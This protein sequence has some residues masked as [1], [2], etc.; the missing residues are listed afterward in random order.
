LDSHLET[1]I[2]AEKYI[3]IAERLSRRIRAG[4][5]HLQPLPAERELAAEVG[6]SHATARKAVQ[7]LLDKGLLFRLENG[8]LSVNRGNRS[9]RKV[10][11]QIVLLAPAWESNE[12]TRWQIAATQLCSRFHC[13]LRVVHYAH[14]DDPLLLGS[15]ERFDG[16]LFMPIPEAMPDSFLPS[17]LQI[18]QPVVVLGRDWTEHGVPSMRLY[19]PALVQKLLDH[20]ASL[21]HQIIDCF[22]V[23]PTDSIVTSLIAQWDIWRAA[24]Q[25][26]GRLI[27][28]PVPAYTETISAAYDV[29]ARRIRAGEFDCTAMLCIT[30]RMAAGAMRAMADHGIR[31]GH[32]VAVC[33]VDDG[34]RAEYS[35]PSLTSLESPDPKPYL[36]ICLEWMLA[37][38]ERQWR[39][40]LLVQPEDLGLAVRQSTVPE[41]DQQIEPKR[42]YSSKGD[43]HR[44]KPFLAK[45]SS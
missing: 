7:R 43:S 6:V 30:E 39:G 14:W 37:G 26:P 31:P 40:P 9:A 20:M 4:D 32:D 42:V 33:T 41:I 23:Q 24:R 34:A 38:K 15:L 18:R 8:R 16:A 2:R 36:A 12:V 29:T 25:M 10:D 17:F 19:R 3:S 45:L 28:E 22:N 5:Y 1:S 21:G 13:S 11:Q 44:A 35:I 27:D